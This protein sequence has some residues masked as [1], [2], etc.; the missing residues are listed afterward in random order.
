MIGQ[1]FI[2]FATAVSFDERHRALNFLRLHVEDG[3][4]AR[5][6]FRQRILDLPHQRFHCLAM[7]GQGSPLRIQLTVHSDHPRRQYRVL[8]D[9]SQDGQHFLVGI[10]RVADLLAD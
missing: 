1:Q 9:R 4:A 6:E 2:R 8:A 3:P 7:G 10:D 5:N